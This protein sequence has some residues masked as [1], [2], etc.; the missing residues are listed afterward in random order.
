[1]PRVMQRPARAQK[2]AVKRGEVLRGRRGG[3]GKTE[4]TKRRVFWRQQEINSAHEY[5]HAYVGICEL[6]RA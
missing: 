6:L 4:R 5:L 1:M 2:A 3:W